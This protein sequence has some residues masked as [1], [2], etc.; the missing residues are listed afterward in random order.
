MEQKLKIQC[1]KN[2]VHSYV[3]RTNQSWRT[4]AFQ[5]IYLCSQA[6]G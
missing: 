3:H 4:I 6:R 2:T 5:I 1:M